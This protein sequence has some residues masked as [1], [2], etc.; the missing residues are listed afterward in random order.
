MG[1]GRRSLGTEFMDIDIAI[2]A[3]VSSPSSIFFASMAGEEIWQGHK[4]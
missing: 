4:G 3:S 2:I 1:D